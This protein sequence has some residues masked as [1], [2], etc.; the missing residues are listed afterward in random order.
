MRIIGNNVMQLNVATTK[1]V[2]EDFLRERFGWKCVVSNLSLDAR[3]QT[4]EVTY[5]PDPAAE[6]EGRDG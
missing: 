2:F 4:I 1:A 6:S 3:S 5:G